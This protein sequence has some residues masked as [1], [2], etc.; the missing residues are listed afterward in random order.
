MKKKEWIMGLQQY[1]FF[2][3]QLQ[4]L[5]NLLFAFRVLIM[6]STVRLYNW[7][8]KWF[9]SFYSR[10]QHL[11]SNKECLL[12]TF[13]ICNYTSVILKKWKN[14]ASNFIIFSLIDQLSLKDPGRSLLANS[15]GWQLILLKK[16]DNLPSSI[17]KIP[18]F[19]SSSSSCDK[20]IHES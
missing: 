9:L 10:S 4:W 3:K 11:L 14:I 5:L 19:I 13:P 2:S 7:G 20:K 12:E 6:D 18:R 1:L 17:K 8:W 15:L 16:A